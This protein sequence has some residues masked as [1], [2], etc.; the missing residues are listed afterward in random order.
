MMA[1]QAVLK[2]F[3]R[4]LSIQPSTLNRMAREGFSLLELMLALALLGGLLAVAWALLGTFRDAETRGW[5]LA[6]QTQTIRTA[7]R[8]LQEDLDH[9]VDSDQPETLFG[10]PREPQFQLK[11]DAR[12]F[13]V[14]VMPDIDSLPFFESMLNAS[15]SQSSSTLAASGLAPASRSDSESAVEG[16]APLG[17]NVRSPWPKSLMRI[18]YQLRPLLSESNN[19]AGA[20]SNPA[21]G[22]GASDSIDPQFELI[23]NE[24]YDAALVDSWS[25]N[26]NSA[27]DS[28][29][30]SLNSNSRPADRELTAADLY[31]QND[32]EDYALGGALLRETRLHGLIQPQFHYSD[33]KVWRSEWNSRLQ[34]GL[35]HAVA[36]SFDFPARSDIQRPEPQPAIPIVSADD[37]LTDRLTDD[38][39][40]DNEGTEASFAETVLDAQPLAEIESMEETALTFATSSSVQIVVLLHGV[41]RDRS[42]N[43]GD[44]RSSVNNSSPASLQGQR[45]FSTEVDQ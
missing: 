5:K 1:A 41:A 7:R 10:P 8:W 17:A 6:H 31:R 29:F 36:F 24:Y 44:S 37:G 30:D 16:T 13:S 45:G 23:R 4:R 25:A 15:A 26:D 34:G 38:Q 14:M 21:D 42:V 27:R 35:P 22:L 33:G 11:G 28:G 43:D 18:E 2:A 9:A 40:L 39:D 19:V 3:P 12:G 32:D 20:T